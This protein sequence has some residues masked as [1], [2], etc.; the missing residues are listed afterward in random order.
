MQLLLW[1]WWWW[2]LLLNYYNLLVITRQCWQAVIYCPKQDVTHSYKT[3]YIFRKYIPQDQ[4]TVRTLPQGALEDN[5]AVSHS[6]WLRLTH[7]IQLIAAKY[8]CLV[9]TCIL[10]CQ[11]TI[12]LLHLNVLNRHLKLSH[13]KFIY[14]L[15]KTFS[16]SQVL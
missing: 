8:I 14:P 11:Q 15:S 10:Y 13:V 4:L 12:R 9:Y 2:R 1:W 16:I 6:Y 5:Q 7:S 3:P